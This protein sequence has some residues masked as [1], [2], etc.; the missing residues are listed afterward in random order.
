MKFNED[1]LFFQK[2]KSKFSEDEMF[3]IGFLLGNMAFAETVAEEKGYSSSESKIIVSDVFS[4]EVV[5][6]IWD[7]L[8]VA[9]NLNVDTSE[10]FTKLYSEKMFSDSSEA[11]NRAL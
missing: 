8:A 5:A 3:I 9:F 11:L 2:V 6:S 7:S 4:E 1:E 10:K